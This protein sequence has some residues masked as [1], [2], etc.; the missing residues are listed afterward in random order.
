VVLD[1]DGV[2]G[3]DDLPR[4]I[5][6]AAV[7]ARDLLTVQV[8]TTLGEVERLLMEETLKYTKGDKALASKLLGIS[9]RTLYR[10]IDKKEDEE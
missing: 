2:I 5:A 8:G 3:E 7:Q 1:R 9:T 6:D 4:I 10:K